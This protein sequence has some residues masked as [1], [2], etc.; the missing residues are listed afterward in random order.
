MKLL[1]SFYTAWAFFVFTFIFVLLFPCYLVLIPVK[2]W[3]RYAYWPNKLWAYLAFFFTGIRIRRSFEKP[4]KRKQQYVYCANHFSLMDIVIFGY[5]PSPFVFVG[6]SSLAK[7]PLFGYMFRKLHITV[8]R[9]RLRSRYETLVRCKEAVDEG[10]SL[11]IFPEGGIYSRQPPRM[12]RFKDGAFRVAI[13]KQIPLVPVTIADNWIILPDTK[14]PLLTW[15][16]AR[17]HFHAPIAT[18]GMDMTQLETLKKQTFD[19]IYQKLNHYY[20]DESR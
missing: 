7:I 12:T 10:K 4:L 13:E 9:E 6:K 3:H 17:I 2:S 8:D 18:E 1:K 19:T 20:P 11:V 16:S 5:S 14:W 15:R